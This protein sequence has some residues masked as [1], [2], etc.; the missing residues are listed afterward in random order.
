MFTI[1]LIFMLAKKE[2]ARTYLTKFHFCISYFEFLTFEFNKWWNIRKY[3]EL[4]KY[5]SWVVFAKEKEHMHLSIPYFFLSNKSVTHSIAS[6]C[7]TTVISR[8]QHWSCNRY[9]IEVYKRQLK[10]CISTTRILRGKK[11]ENLEVELCQIHW[12]IYFALK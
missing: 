3:K 1:V 4:T 11:Q 8:N 9:F 5:S 6:N 12:T 7:E 2:S 10:L